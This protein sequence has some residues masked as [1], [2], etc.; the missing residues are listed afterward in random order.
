MENVTVSVEQNVVGPFITV[1]FEGLPYT[2]FVRALL[3]PHALKAMTEMGPE[4]KEVVKT[5]LIDLVP[6]PEAMDAPAGTDQE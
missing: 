1:G 3:L 6:C 5:T 4:T 2:V